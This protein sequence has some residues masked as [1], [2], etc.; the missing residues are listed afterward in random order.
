ME[1]IKSEELKNAILVWTGRETSSFPLRDDDLVF[2]NFSK[3]GRVV[4]DQIKALEADFYKSDA[5]LRAANLIE[6]EQMAIQQFIAAHPDLDLEIAR[7]FAWCY[8]F[9]YK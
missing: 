3:N 7:A 6:M 9:D 2:N 8:S 4:L 5:Y 1:Q